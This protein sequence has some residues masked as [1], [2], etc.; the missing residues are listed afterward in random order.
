MERHFLNNQL[1]SSIRCRVFSLEIY[2]KEQLGSLNDFIFRR[3]SIMVV[4]PVVVRMTQVRFLPVAL[5]FFA[6]SIEAQ[7]NK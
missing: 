1:C 5:K 2:E 6:F 7:R 4:H 3:G